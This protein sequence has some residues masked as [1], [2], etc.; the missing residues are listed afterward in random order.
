MSWTLREAIFLATVNLVVG[1]AL[2]LL[3]SGGGASDLVMKLLTS[4]FLVQQCTGFE[5]LG[6]TDC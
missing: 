1:E 4:V 6:D 3:K 5:D 2:P